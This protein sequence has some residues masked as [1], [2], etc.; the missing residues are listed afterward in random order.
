ML[1]NIIFKISIYFFL[2]IFLVACD[3]VPKSTNWDNPIDEDGS[4]WNPPSISVMKDTSGI[5]INDSIE[6]T[7][8]G[9]DHSGSIEKYIWSTDGVNWKD[10]TTNGSKIYSWSTAGTY[11][12]FVRAI[13]NDGVASPTDS[14][15]L[16]IE[17]FAPSL[18][19][20]PSSTTHPVNDSINISSLAV[21]TNGV[22]ESY[23]WS[24]DGKNWNDTTT[25]SSKKFG[26]SITGN[27]K[28][29]VK[30]I[31]DDNIHSN[32]DSI[33]ISIASFPPII[34]IMPD[35][36]RHPINDSIIITTT[37][38]D[39]N[40]VIESYIWSFD[41]I[42]WNDTTTSSSNYFNWPKAG[43]YKVYAKAIDDDNIH[44][45]KDSISITIESFPPIITI[46]SDSIGHP[47]NDSIII[48]STGFDSNGVIESYIW[49]YD[50][51][52]WKDTTTSSSN[53]FSWSK[54][55]NYYVYIKVI[56]DDGNLSNIDSTLITIGSFPPTVEALADIT[57]YP[58]NDLITVRAKG[59]DSNGSI[60]FYLWSKDRTLWS[61]TTITSTQNYYWATSGK[62]WVYVK[63]IDNDGV[64]SA[65]DSVRISIEN[66]A[67]TVEL[68]QDSTI[69]PINDEVNI[70]ALGNDEFGFIQFYYWSID[71]GKTWIDSTSQPTNAFSWS[72]P[73]KYWIYTKV[74]DDDL[75]YS[76]IDSM[77]ITIENFPPTVK[78]MSDSIGHP[79]NDTIVINANGTDS[80]GSIQ[81]YFWA[82]D[83]D[84]IW[85]LGLK[86]GSHF[87][88]WP[89]SGSYW[90][91]VKV[92]DDDGNYS[93]IDSVQIVVES[94]LPT[95]S[96]M[97]DISGFPINDNITV[98]AVGNDANG[99]IQ[100]YHWSLDNG[101]TWT[102]VTN[103]GSNS[104]S[105]SASGEHWVHVKVIDD[106]GN[107][108]NIDSVKIVTEAFPPS[109]II[110][111]D[112]IGHP[113][114]DD[115]AIS[116]F[117][118][119]ING[120]VQSYHW[121]T[122]KGST[123]NEVTN[124]GSKVFN[125]SAAGEHWV[126][127]KV[128]DDDGNFSNIDSVKIITEAYPPSVII[129]SDSIG[130]PINDD[131]AI[132]AFGTDINGTVQSYHWSTDKGSTWNEVTNIGSKVFNWSAEGDYWVYVKVIDDDGCYSNIDSIQ[133]TVYGYAP[134]VV[135]VTDDTIGQFETYSNTLIATDQNGTIVFYAWDVNEDGVWDDSSATGSFS[136]THIAGGKVTVNWY[137]QDDDGLKAFDTFSLLY[138]QAPNIDSIV[139]IKWSSWNDDLDHGT[140]QIKVF[141]DDADGTSD[142]STYNLLIP[143]KS[144]DSTNT[145]GLFAIS[146]VSSN[147]TLN[148]TVEISDTYGSTTSLS[149]T[150]TS[151]STPPCTK[152]GDPFFIDSRDM[153][154][155]NC[156]IIGDQ[157]WMTQNLNYS[158][159][160]GAGSKTNAIGYCYGELDHSDASTCI[161]YGRL[162]TWHTAM[163]GES[164]SSTNPSNVRGLCPSGWH[165]PSLEEFIELNDFIELDN[166]VDGVGKSLKST[167][168]WLNSGNGTDDY[169]F[170]AYPTGSRSSDGTYFNNSG[171]TSWWNTYHY[172]NDGVQLHYLAWSLD[173]FFM[174]GGYDYSGKAARCLLNK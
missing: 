57:I 158:G 73:G 145:T 74:I 151:L 119:D 40:G 19:I 91:Y 59:K 82:I 26:W 66:F 103:S 165:L 122:D 159:D 171:F 144:F 31:D 128:I 21:D 32:K 52:N 81:S 130:H 15:V 168:G 56:D 146:D 60:K 109:V 141:A 23:I 78:A 48:T 131:I 10:S 99:I 45:E 135:P 143:S 152:N 98:T 118:T 62:H 18:V 34:T 97:S 63:V 75:I 77:L 162:Y 105:W 163:N 161:V 147:E 102:E 160:D 153:Q 47:I 89:Q 84:N 155:Y 42:N 88:S 14:V 127:V 101:S 170:S 132:S 69:Y 124:T 172:G 49:S 142:I 110:M 3:S 2:L 85:S 93:N 96:A 140:L 11:T 136:F 16:G 7:A 167:T 70:R 39:S 139:P 112:S 148:S 51:Y 76:N 12:I 166:G 17:I 61:D 86:N 65:I 107:Y 87:Y 28:I 64:H 4:N 123:W 1:N 120:T 95:V 92:V 24:I 149:K 6:V 79:I 169:G 55:G 113:I 25:S 43:I 133:V 20:L 134:I 104:F 157:A 27:Y 83:K 90:V 58:I 22:I 125:W 9:L 30:A 46:M 116:A 50:G 29:Y 154:Q 13:D 72:I 5:P 33:N 44:S 150:L 138:N 68:I 106:D 35:S 117:G 111:P 156:A 8:V 164:S 71:R 126:Y 100:S 108:S 137:A 36:I 94:Y 115:I 54:L 80:N 129:M 41:G 114:N 174:D 173:S 67:P 37:A 53:I 38:I 121:S